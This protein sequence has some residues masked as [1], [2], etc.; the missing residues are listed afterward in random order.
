MRSLTRY[1]FS[2]LIM[3][4][5]LVTLGLTMAVWLTQSLRFIDYIV[6]RGLPAST[7]FSFVAL[8]IPTFIGVVLPISCFVSVLFVYNKLTTDSEMV[9]MRA[10]GLSQLQMAKPALLAGL[11]C[12]LVVYAVS[13][14]FQP[15]S[16]R[17]FKDLQYSIRNNYS[18]IL[19]QEG[20]FNTITDDITVYV[21]DRSQDGQIRGILVHDTRNPAKP[22]TLLADSGAF[23]ES[24]DGPR[25][26]LKNGN[27][28][29][30]DRKSGRI[31]MLYFDS[32]TVELDTFQD[33]IPLRW[34][35]PSER[36]LGDLLF[37]GD[38]KLDRINRKQLIAEGHQR[39]VMP[40][41]ALVFTAL[42]LAALLGG[43]FNRRG[44]IKRI[45][46]AVLAVVAL[47]AGSLAI[48]DAAVKYLEAVPV[49]YALAVLPFILAFVLLLRRPKPP[50]RQIGPQSPAAA[51]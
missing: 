47:E 7:F 15:I 35:G 21:R 44:Q 4:T 24:K 25:V 48:H 2:Q 9:V 13:L 51:V 42:G 45:I 49:M 32:Y 27:R 19:L 12:T 5:L 14:Y 38:S 36:F 22:V 6:N 26:V 18:D 20:E 10:A 31:S 8:L 43:E 23:V 39:L 34:Q 40:L 29:E 1:V 37:P 28:Q 17:A 46:A 30:I 33:S 41:Y 16:Y 3:A 11:I 50:A